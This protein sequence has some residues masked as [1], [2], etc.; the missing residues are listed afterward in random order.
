MKRAQQEAEDISNASEQ[1]A[2]TLYD[3]QHAYHVKQR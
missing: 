3:V 2:L 1:A